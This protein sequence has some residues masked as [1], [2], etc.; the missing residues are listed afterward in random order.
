MK[1]QASMTVEAAGA[2]GGGADNAYDSDGAGH[3]L[4]RQGSGKFCVA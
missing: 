3:E 2:H 4:E 1:L